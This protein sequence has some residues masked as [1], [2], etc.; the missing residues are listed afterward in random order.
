[1]KSAVGQTPAI[2]GSK[3]VQTYHRGPGYFEVDVDVGSSTVA[4]SILRLVQGY[5]T[6]LSIDLAFLFEGQTDEELPEAILGGFR[7]ENV[8]LLSDLIPMNLTFLP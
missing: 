3:L 4:G 1:M 8:S 7:F 2:L 6:S 5:V